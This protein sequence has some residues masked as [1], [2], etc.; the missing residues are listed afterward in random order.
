MMLW[1]CAACT[2]IRRT[3][4]FLRQPGWLFQNFV[5]AKMQGSVGFYMEVKF[6]SGRRSNV[7]VAH[8]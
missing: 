8:A 6:D 3:L 1:A 7:Q 5:A 2:L 4:T